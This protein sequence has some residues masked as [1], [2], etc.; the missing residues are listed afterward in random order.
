M[1]APHMG[2]GKNLRGQSFKLEADLYR[3]KAEVIVKLDLS[4][5]FIEFERD[6][7]TF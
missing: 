2:S 7:D 4:L 3:K 5:L 6:P 1:A